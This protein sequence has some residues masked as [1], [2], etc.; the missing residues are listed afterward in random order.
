MKSKKNKAKAKRVLVRLSRPV[1]QNDWVYNGYKGIKFHAVRR[2]DIYEI[3]IPYGQTG[4]SLT[5]YRWPSQV[6]E[7]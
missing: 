7:L 5:V 6:E 2:G 4:G 1:A 3:I